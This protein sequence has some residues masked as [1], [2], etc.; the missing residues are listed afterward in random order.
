MEARAD[1][2][3]DNNHRV[4]IY[5]DGAC[6]RQGKHPRLRCAGIGV[7]FATGHPGNVSL[8]LPGKC[9]TNQR[10]ELL[11]VVTAMRRDPRPVHIKTD[12]EYVVRGFELYHQWMH[13]GW[14]GSHVDLW[15]QFN[16][17]IAEDPSRVHIS[18][19]LG[20]ATWLDV[21]LGKSSRE[22]KLGNDAADRLAV[23][24]SN[25]HPAGIVLQR[26]VQ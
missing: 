11:A 9:Q 23:D 15:T 6:K 24:G 2:K 17:I 25:M 8:P 13:E 26:Q 14:K 16:E 3:I 19:V 4:V 20:H 21:R 7:H 12:S 18:K 10:A 1:E 22:D 5:T